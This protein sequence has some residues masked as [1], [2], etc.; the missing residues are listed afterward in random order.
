MLFALSIALAYALTNI[1][2]LFAFFAIAT[3]GRYKQALIGF[4]FAQILVVVGAYVAGAGVTFLTPHALGYL[5]IVPL[6]LGVWE[7]WRNMSRSGKSTDTPKPAHSIFSAAVIFLALSADTFI[8]IAAF[9]ADTAAVL[10]R[11]VLLGALIAVTGLV[12]AGTLLTK[13]FGSNR[14]IQWFFENLSPFVMIAAGIYILLD[15]ATDTL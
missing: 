3:S 6:S 12:V 5:G 9:F 1:D 10:D 13:S 8:L 15:T 11:H 14:R 2:G 7:V 4:L